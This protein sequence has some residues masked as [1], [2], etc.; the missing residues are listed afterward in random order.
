VGGS[1]CLLLWRGAEMFTF[2]PN[3]DYLLQIP[4]WP[5]QKGGEEGIVKLNGKIF[6]SSP[7]HSNYQ[8]SPA[9]A[10]NRM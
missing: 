4:L 5:Y 1:F 6:P 2:E 8:I 9:I 7:R 3:K 10:I